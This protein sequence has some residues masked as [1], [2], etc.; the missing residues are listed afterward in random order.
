MEELGLIA[1]AGV[2]GVGK[3][4]LARELSNLFSAGLI[5]EEYDLNPFHPRQLGGDHDSALAS[6]L[7]FLL[8]RARQLAPEAIAGEAT[9]LCDYLF[10][11][12]RI[13]AELTLD[14]HQLGIFTEVERIVAA[15]I[16]TPTIVI[17]LRDTV[18]NCL[19]RITRRNRELESNITAAWL[20]RLGQCYDEL[21]DRWET[22]PVLRLDCS[23]YDLRQR[24]DVKM[25]VAALE[26]LPCCS[27]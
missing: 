27:N 6:E 23:E 14:E 22:C 18:D 25:V 19:D 21:F 1:V 5:C 24:S 8:S 9:V 3:T 20:G 10:E 12:N 2:V 11:K 16:A 26:N 4:T 17:Y 7:F 15:R 13:F